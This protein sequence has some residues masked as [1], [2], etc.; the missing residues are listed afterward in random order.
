MSRAA[1]FFRV[2]KKK[3]CFAS[4][5][6]GE[7]AGADLGGGCSGVRTPSPHEMTCGFLIQLVFCIKI[8]LCDQSVSP[9]VSGATPP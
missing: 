7:E 5:G 9:F 1:S 2:R 8:C 3:A 6:Q 4:W